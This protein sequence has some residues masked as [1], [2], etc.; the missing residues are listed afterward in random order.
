M[1]E[2]KTVLITGSSSGIGRAAAHYFSAKGWQV[3]ASMR[4]PEKETELTKL[5]GV[6]CL[7][8]DVTDTHSIPHAVAEVRKRFGRIDVLVNNAGYGLVGPFENMTPEQIRRQFDTNVFGLME[9]ARAVL[10][11]MRESGGGII[12]NVAS[13]GGR[14]TFPFYSLYHASKWAVEGF[15]EA[16]RYEL[17]PLGVTVKIVEPGPIKTDFYQRSAEQVMNARDAGYGACSERASRRMERFVA[18]FASA[19]EAVARVI[20]RAATDGKSKLRYPAGWA[21]YPILLGRR[22]L[23]YG[24]FQGLVRWVTLG[25]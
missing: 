11:V 5:A 14:V 15:S 17:D 24:F 1:T 2:S 12:I 9:T 21:A 22:F 20:Y 18:I 3:A 13:I 25:R 8:L 6:H 7:R 10:P 4:S 16:L 23:P 19:P